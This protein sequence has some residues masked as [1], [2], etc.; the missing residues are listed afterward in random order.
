[1]KTSFKTLRIKAARWLMK[2]VRGYSNLVGGPQL[3]DWIFNGLT[4]DQDL[5]QN[6]RKMLMRSRDLWKEN[7]IARKFSRDLLINV[8]GADGISLQMRITDE[9]GRIPT[10][11]ELAFVQEKQR[12][13]D[14]RKAILREHGITTRSVDFL[15]AGQTRAGMPDTFANNM[16]ERE[17]GAWQRNCA[18]NRRF[19]YQQMRNQRLNMCARDGECFIRLVRGFDN[20]HGFAIQIIASEFC[21]H[22]YNVVLTNGNEI[23]MGIEY[24]ANDA[25]V[26]YHFIVKQ[27][28]SWQYENFYSSGGRKLQRVDARDIIHYKIS[29]DAGSGRGVP[30][31]ISAIPKVRHQEK[32]E[33]AS[34]IAARAECCK[35]GHYKATMPGMDITD[36]ADRIEEGGKTLTENVEPAQWKA[37]PFGWEPVA[38]D[39]K[40]PT[41]NFAAFKKEMMRSIAA[42]LPGENYNTLASDYEGV[43]F[44]SYKAA[45]ND[46]NE[47]YKALQAWDIDVAERPIFEAWLEMALLSGAIPLPVVKFDKFNAPRFQGRRWQGLQPVEEATANKINLALG[48]TSRT[49]ITEEGPHNFE[50]I[51]ED[52]ALEKILLEEAGLN[53]AV[54][55]KQPYATAPKDDQGED[56]DDEDEEEEGDDA[57]S[58]GKNRIAKLNGTH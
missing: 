44:T 58:F 52:L 7:G 4:E 31:I 25:V 17:W 29:D 57:K 50:D 47:E 34:V 5:F 49:I 36:L 13:I 42:S 56:E 43:N 1:M 46:C 23:R 6:W 21:D 48:L 9:G 2:G 35:G 32:Y 55:T 11:R 41:A 3:T 45:R 37:L 8:F 39:P 20:K 19:N 12:E 26:A 53:A 33:E 18:A 30:W 38:H 40:H 22:D 10:G 27:A 54:D 15:Y 28:G 16:I 51:V 24:D 14:H